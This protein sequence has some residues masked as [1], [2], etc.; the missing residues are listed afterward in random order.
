VDAEELVKIYTVTDPNQAEIIKG[1]LQ[2][3]GIRCEIGGESQAGFTGLWDVDLYV[4]AED[5]DR[6]TKII[7]SHEP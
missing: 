6:A 1:A 4:R 7:E 2:A 3:D 5:A